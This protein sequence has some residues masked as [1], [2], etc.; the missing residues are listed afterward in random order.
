MYYTWY[1][2]ATALACPLVGWTGSKVGPNKMVALGLLVLPIGLL[3]LGPSEII[4]L[5]NSLT[6]LT[7]GLVILGFSQAMIIVPSIEIM[8]E[9]GE[10][11]ASQK[12]DEMSIDSS[13]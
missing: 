13:D 9:A 6:L 8:V 4:G 5:P 1:N 3:F 10:N 11:K 7:I 12:L 2:G